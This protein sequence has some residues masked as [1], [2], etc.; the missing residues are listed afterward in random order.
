MYDTVHGKWDAE[1]SVGDG[2][3]IINGYEVQ[4][5]S[6]RDPAKIEWKRLQVDLVIDATG[7]FNDREGSSKHIAAGASHVLI[8]AP[9]KQMDLTVV[10]AVNDHL[11]DPSKSEKVRQ[12]LKTPVLV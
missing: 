7:K 1:I 4:I 5:V 11:Y 3:L 6:E 8:T 10:M 9:G 12:D 2:K